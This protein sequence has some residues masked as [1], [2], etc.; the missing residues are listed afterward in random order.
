MSLSHEAFAFPDDVCKLESPA[1]VLI[2]QTIYVNDGQVRVR[3][4]D[5]PSNCSYW[6][7]DNNYLWSLSLE[8]PFRVGSGNLPI[9]SFLKPEAVPLR[10]ASALW[11]NRLGT[12]LYAYG[13]FLPSE[14]TSGINHQ[15]VGVPVVWKYDISANVW[16]TISSTYNSFVASNSLEYATAPGRG[17]SFAMGGVASYLTVPTTS[18]NW[19]GPPVPGLMI[20]DSENLSL[21]NYTTPGAPNMGQVANGNFVY[22]PYGREGVL[23]LLSG[24]YVG[25]TGD[26][27]TAVRQLGDRDPNV[28]ESGSDFNARLHSTRYTCSTSHLALGSCKKLRSMLAYQIRATMPVLQS[29][30]ATKLALSISLCLEVTGAAEHPTVISAGDFSRGIDILSLPSFRWFHFFDGLN[31]PTNS[32]VSGCVC[33]VVGDKI[34]RIGGWS[35]VVDGGTVQPGCVSLVSVLDLS[36]LTWTQYFDP[37]GHEYR[38]PTTIANWAVAHASPLAGW[39]IGVQDIFSWRVA[40]NGTSI[41]IG[42]TTALTTHHIRV[43][44]VVGGVLGGVIFIIAL[45]VVIL[46]LRK[47]KSKVLGAAPGTP[48]QQIGELQQRINP[49]PLAST[50]ETRYEAQ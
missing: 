9:Q 31:T 24:D 8:A 40:P 4:C 41:P 13:G 5:A 15:D 32:S 7:D 23:V 48:G 43:G 21:V 38:S 11:H 47:R 45:M 42:G 29:P 46:L 50:Q 35:A 14:N 34:I 19:P 12:E 44:V 33:H 18:R 10:A 30:Q 3:H 37:S 26:N 36:N 39:N 17:L 27:R 20:F 1:S 2:G 28:P 25:S 16:S 22:V 49:I 6:T